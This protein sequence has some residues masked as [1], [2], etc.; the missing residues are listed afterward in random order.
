MTIF[1]TIEIDGA[2]KDVLEQLFVKG[3]TWDGN[4]T[5]KSGRSTLIELGL[6]QHQNGWAFLTAEGV[7][8]ATEWDVEQLRRR[9][10]QG[11]F[12]KAVRFR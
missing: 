12:E 4:I 2:A 1:K 3:P 5:S 7:R 11:W 10:Y 9:H 6:A 8:V